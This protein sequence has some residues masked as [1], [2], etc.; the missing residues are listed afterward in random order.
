MRQKLG[1]P[2]Q[3]KSIETIG[4]QPVGIFR[5][6]GFENYNPENNYEFL[7]STFARDCSNEL[8]GTRCLCSRIGI[9]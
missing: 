3:R 4:R 8:S 5:T 9:A 7:P 2:N 1:G 6:S